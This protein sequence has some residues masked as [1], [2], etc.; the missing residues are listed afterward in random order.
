MPSIHPNASV[1]PEA[2][3][4]ADVEVGPYVVIDGPV[5]VGAGTRIIAQAHLTGHT[6]IGPECVI[7]PFAAIGGPPQDRAHT[8]ERSYCRV[9]AR[10]VLREGVTIHRGTA[11]ES[12]TSVGD[13]CMIMAWAHVAHN[14]T[15]AD[16]VI[17]I[18]GVQLAGH[19]SVGRCTVIGGLAAV[20]QFC[21]I[22]EYAMVGG[23]ALITQDAL[24]FM[25]HVDRNICTGINRIGLRRNGF[26][27]EAIDELRTI[28]RRFFRSGTTIG[29]AAR[30]F[31][32][33]ARTDAGRRLIEFALAPSRRSIGGRS[34]GA[35]RKRGQEDSTVAD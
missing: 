8:G 28:H 3:L 10:T 5:R 15:V 32:D 18:N 20:H 14:C 16:R 7:H 26:T 35:A 31:A 29:R 27:A 17:L 2:E 1:S 23:G 13:D 6:E 33:Q 9:G 4:E 34:L 11:P 30:D 21:R 25:S 19:C 24:P 12:T 22:G